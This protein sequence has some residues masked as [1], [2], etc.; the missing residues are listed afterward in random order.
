MLFKGKRPP[1]G[2]GIGVWLTEAPPTAGVAMGGPVTWDG[3]A[4]LVDLFDN[5]RSKD[6]PLVLGIVNR[7]TKNYTADT[8]GVDI[9]DGKCTFS[10]LQVNS[11]TPTRL[12][13][14]YNAP[15][16]T[17]TVCPAPFRFRRVTRLTARWT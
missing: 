3:V 15:Q 8:D 5:D 7:H 1:Y 14:T 6:T 11:E 2:D 10:A 17:L 13:L 9:A 4:V 12:T 16:R